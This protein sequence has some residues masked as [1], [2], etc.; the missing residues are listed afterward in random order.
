VPVK[1]VGPCGQRGC[2]A[3]PASASMLS[4]DSLGVIPGRLEQANYGAQLRT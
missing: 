4:D 1:I 2:R 3:P